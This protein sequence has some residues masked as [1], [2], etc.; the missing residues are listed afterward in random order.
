MDIKITVSGPNGEEHTISL[1][2]TAEGWWDSFMKDALAAGHNVE[3]ICRTLTERIKGTVPV[4]TSK[5]PGA[6]LPTIHD[7]KA[8][9]SSFAEGALQ[10]VEASAREF[11]KT[12]T[13][14]MHRVLDDAEAKMATPT[15]PANTDTPAPDAQPQKS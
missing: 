6:A 1:A 10:N 13:D 11:I 14:E 2:Q 3:S 15:P 9:V 7:L 5:E 4:I 12:L 8:V